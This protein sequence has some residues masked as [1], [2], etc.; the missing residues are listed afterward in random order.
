MDTSDLEFAEKVGAG[1]DFFAEMRNGDVL[2]RL[3]QLGEVEGVIRDMTFDCVREAREDLGISWDAIGQALG[4][5]RQTVW[6]RWHEY[7]EEPSARPSRRSN[8]SESSG[9]WKM[10][11]SGEHLPACERE[12]RFGTNKVLGSMR[13][14]DVLLLQA[15]LTG[16]HDPDGRIRSA[17]LFDSVEPDSGESLKLWGRAFRFVIHASRCIETEPFSLE[18]VDGLAGVYVRQGMMNHQRI[19]AEDVDLVRKAAGLEGMDL[20]RQ[21]A[22]SAGR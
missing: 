1:L 20:G 21:L 12:L 4:L 9:W 15:N 13:R 5:S 17:L 7:V 14:G 11:V 18:N 19:L 10:N 22:D 2:H 6:E 3:H 16:P 8:P